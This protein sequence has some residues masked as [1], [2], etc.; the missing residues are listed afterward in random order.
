MYNLSVFIAGDEAHPQVLEILLDHN[1]NANATDVWGQNTALNE[2]AGQGLYDSG[3][4][5]LDCGTDSTFLVTGV[6]PILMAVKLEF[7]KT[8][9]TFL[10]LT[11]FDGKDWVIAGIREVVDKQHAKIFSYTCKKQPPI[12]DA[13][14]LS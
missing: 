9:Q 6:R 11:K 13:S 4:L 10:P 5:L 7:P 14:T 2:A 8:I 3:I 1:G 12:E